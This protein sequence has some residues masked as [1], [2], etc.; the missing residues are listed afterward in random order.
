MALRLARVILFVHD[1]EACA[2]FYK[3]VLGLK[4][5]PSIEWDGW[6][7]FEAGGV[8]VALHKA[9]GKSKSGRMGANAP[10]KLSFYAKDVAALRAKLIKRGAK[11]GPVKKYGKL[12]LC[13]GADPAGNR[14]QLS[15]R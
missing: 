15:N 11:L 14:I 10:H 7:E 2:A 1:M 9:W 12:R 13:D 4:A 3:D 8:C 5:L 6:Q